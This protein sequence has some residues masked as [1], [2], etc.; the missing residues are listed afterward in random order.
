M[1]DPAGQSWNVSSGLFHAGGEV[2]F[3]KAGE[4]SDFSTSGVGVE[5]FCLMQQVDDVCLAGCFTLVECR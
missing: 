4:T 1:P 2:T 3:E 5:V